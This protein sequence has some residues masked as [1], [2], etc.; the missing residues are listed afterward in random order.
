MNTEEL[1]ELY[2][3]YVCVNCANK[4]RDVCNLHITINKEA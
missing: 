3:K 1:F 4:N 2:K